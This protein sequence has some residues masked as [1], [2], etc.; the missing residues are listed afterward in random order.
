MLALFELTL[1]VVVLFVEHA[2]VLHKCVDVV[3]FLSIVFLLLFYPVSFIFEKHLFQVL[4]FLRAFLEL[5][6]SLVFHLVLEPLDELNFLRKLLLLFELSAGF[7]GIELP[8]TAFLFQSDLLL[9]G[10]S[11][12][13]LTLAKELHVL[14]LQHFV[15]ASLVFLFDFLVFL[16]LK[17]PVQLLLNQLLS[18]LLTD[19]FLLHLFEVEQGVKLL[20]C[21]PFIVLS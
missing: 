14:F 7:L 18:L 3:F 21:R 15:H 13:N 17:L 2:S 10:C 16:L 6:L 11:L 19:S 9:L 8:V 12:F 1:P 20:D 5:H 4:T